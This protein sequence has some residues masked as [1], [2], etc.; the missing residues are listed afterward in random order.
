MSA[1]DS[2]S[3]QTGCNLFAKL[4]ILLLIVAS[5]IYIYTYPDYLKDDTYITRK[6][7]KKYPQLQVRTLFSS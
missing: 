2:L 6:Y 4:I 5:F 1:N 3:S 7:S